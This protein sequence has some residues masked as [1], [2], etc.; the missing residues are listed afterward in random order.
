MK[1]SKAGMRHLRS[2]GK[3]VSEPALQPPAVRRGSASTYR[4]SANH[5]KCGLRFAAEQVGSS[6]EQ[7]NTSLERFNKRIGDAA[8]GSGPAADALERLNLN[9]QRLEQMG[10]GEVMERVAERFENVESQ[11]RRASL[12]Q[13]LFGQSGRELLPLLD[14]GA[15][16]IRRFYAGARLS[17]SARRHRFNGQR[18][19]WTM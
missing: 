2:V 18:P 16:G 4:C 14:Q 12:A 7:L 9:A 8:R 3:S 17:A 11:A 1:S 13:N 6:K 10:L 5:R 15:E 19:L